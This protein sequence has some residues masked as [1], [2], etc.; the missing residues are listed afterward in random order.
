[1]LSYHPVV[2][3][4]VCPFTKPDSQSHGQSKAFVEKQLTIYTIP[5]HGDISAAVL[6]K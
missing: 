3:G 6:S 2:C 1:M 5:S 4:C